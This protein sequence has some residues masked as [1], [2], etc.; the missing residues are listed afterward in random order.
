MGVHSTDANAEIEIF[1]VG[2][3]NGD[4]R[5]V[6]SNSSSE[7]RVEVCLNGSYFSVCDDFWD[8]LDAQ[9]V[10]RQLSFSTLPGIHNKWFALAANSEG[11]RHFCRFF[12]LEECLLW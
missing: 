8:A 11:G 10:C 9:V 1:I 6:G 2:C 5:L 4:V 7:G 3:L 12:A